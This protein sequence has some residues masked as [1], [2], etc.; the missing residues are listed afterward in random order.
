MA[1][2]VRLQH[3]A[4]RD[5]RGQAGGRPHALHVP[6]DGR[7]F[8]KEGI[9]GKFGHERNARP[10]GGGHR[11]RARPA[12]ADHHAN[13]GEFI[14]GLNDGV[15]VLAIGVAAIDR[16]V[17][18]QAI[19]QRG[20]RGDGIP[21]HELHAAEDRAQ[22]RGRIAV[23]QERAFGLGHAL[24]T[25][26]IGLG[27]V[28]LRPFARQLHD[29]EVQIDRFAFAA[30]VETQRRFDLAHLDIEQ[31]HEDAD[32]D[33][34]GD[35]GP[36]LGIGAGLARELVDG[37]GIVRDVVA[38]DGERLVDRVQADAARF[39]F[40]DVLGDRRFV[41]RHQNFGALA[42]GQVAVFADADG[43]P[44]GQAL[45]VGGEQVL[46]AGRDAHLVNG[47]DQRV[48]GGLAAG[49][50]DRG[51]RDGEVVDDRRTISS[52]ARLGLGL[53]YFHGCDLA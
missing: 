31:A 5:A 3:I 6:D 28:G 17:V 34:V 52:G 53:G 26:R 39:Q 37:H 21:R 36:Q 46:A 10:G 14:F 42:A 1:Q 24:H 29:V 40:L 32:V 44:R 8:G 35:V 18:V 22:G 9:A 19:G 11:T 38:L 7:N 4:L 51:D 20:G 25:K 13:R 49:A 43:E 41:H 45:N 15:G 33:H 30:E 50:V 48:V 27:E 16:Q 23:D 2:K 12:R 47:A